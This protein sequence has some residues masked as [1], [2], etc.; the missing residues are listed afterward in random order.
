MEF[1]ESLTEVNTENIE[2]TSQ[3]TG[4]INVTREDK[5][6]SEN[7]LTHEDYFKVKAIFKERTNE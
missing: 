6:I 4:L 3:T 1:V 2:P 7:M 5:V